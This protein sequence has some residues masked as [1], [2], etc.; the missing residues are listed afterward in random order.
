MPETVKLKCKSGKVI[1]VGQIIDSYP[2]QWT[3]FQTI[4]VPVYDERFLD[5]FGDSLRFRI[6]H[7]HD[8]IILIT[9]QRRGG[10]SMLMS[11]AT[12]KVDPDFPVGKVAFPLQ[13]FNKTLSENPRFDADKN[14]WPQAVL[15]EAGYDLY[16]G[17]WMQAVS[18]NMVRKF[19]VIGEKG[20]TVWLVL[21]HRMKLIKGIREDMAHW[22]LN[23][24]LF[25]DE[26]HRGFAILRRAK[27]NE[28]REEAYWMPEAA[29]MF[30]NQEDAWWKEY[31]EKKRAFVD[32]V[33]GDNPEDLA[34]KGRHAT[35]VLEQRNTYIRFIKKELK[36]S[37]EVIANIG[38]LDRTAVQHIIHPPQR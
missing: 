13:E 28:W 36:L 9:G 32:K 38:G 4:A 7:G 12:R 15:D 19:E 6:K 18:K 2:V 24:E 31:M 37:D 10:K 21:P 34:P 35:K 25:G 29:F 3:R 30:P 33:A 5:Y 22:W 23:V 17:N 14:I 16:A 26:E 20:Q 8:N 27:P 11:Q 1:E